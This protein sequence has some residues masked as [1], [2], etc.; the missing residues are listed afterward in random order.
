MN[1]LIVL[2][3][4]DTL[5][6]ELVHVELLRVACFFRLA[7][8]DETPTTKPRGGVTSLAQLFSVWRIGRRGPF[9]D[10]LDWKIRALKVRSRK[11]RQSRPRRSE[12][13]GRP[14]AGL[15]RDSRR[16]SPTF[17]E[18]RAAEVAGAPSIPATQIIPNRGAVG[19]PLPASRQPL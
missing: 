12:R 18:T 6:Q 11:A 19:Y 3:Y 9:A 13:T 4:Y 1:D 7:F 2:D 8:R 16:S 5:A 15:A 10:D 17:I 14:A